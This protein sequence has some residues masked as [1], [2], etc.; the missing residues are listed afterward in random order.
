ML[1]VIASAAAVVVAGYVYLVHE[2]LGIEGAGLMLVRAVAFLSLFA[3]LANVA[4]RRSNRATPVTVAVDASL[5]MDH[6]GAEWRAVLDTAVALAGRN[7]L[8]LRFGSSVAPFDSTPPGE[9]RSRVGDVLR[10]AA[11]RGGPAIVVTDG[12]LDDFAALPQELRERI[13]VVLLPRPA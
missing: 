11:A 9:G 12:E 6:P 5:S 3:L 7:G 4:V 8:L 13:R 10:V 2:R 1:W